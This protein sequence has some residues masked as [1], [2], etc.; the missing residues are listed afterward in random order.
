[1]KIRG[2][3]TVVAMSALA[4]GMASATSLTAET[5]SV[6]A[7]DAIEMRG[8]ATVDISVGTP[9][10]VQIAAEAD[11][12][13]LIKT[14]VH[15]KTLVIEYMHDWW[16]WDKGPVHVSIAMPKLGGYSLGGAG[17]TNITGLSGGTTSISLNGA[18]NV[19]ASGKLDKLAINLNGTGNADFSDVPV[20]DA[21]VAVNGTGS[22]RVKPKNGLNA[23]INGVGSIIYDGAP[24]HL[25]TAVNGIGSV[26]Q[27]Q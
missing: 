10:S 18:G 19:K 24:Q 13:A 20:D 2:M 22:V 1:M 4:A 8:A 26:R 25:V 27:A 3:L 14:E 21:S 17:D 5:R 11:A 9:Q 23:S 16:N 15:G 7:F 12:L 6:G